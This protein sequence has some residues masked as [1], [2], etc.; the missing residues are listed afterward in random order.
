MKAKKY[1]VILIMLIVLTTSTMSYARDKR[2]KP[3][4]S[5]SNA[6]HVT[7]TKHLDPLKAESGVIVVTV[8]NM[9]DA[10]LYLPKPFTPLYTPQDHLMN[11]IFQVFGEDGKEAKFIGRFIR[12]LQDNPNDYYGRIEPGQAISHEVDLA[13][14]YDLSKG[15]SYQITYQQPFV[16]HIKMDEN[17]QIAGHDEFAPESS[18]DIWV[19]ASLVLKKSAEIVRPLTDGTS[20]VCLQDKQDVI[21][22]AKQNVLPWTK[23]AKEHLNNLYYNE[24]EIDGSGTT[25]YSPKIRQ[26]AA[27]E[28]WFGTPDNNTPGE[29][30]PWNYAEYVD[31]DDFVMFGAV[32]NI[33]SRYGG[34]KYECGCGE[35]Y[36]NTA[37]WAETQK[38]LIHICDKFF[39]LPRE[40]GRGDSQLLT[41]IHELSHFPGSYG[42][43]TV[44]YAYGMESARTLVG[45][46]RH[47]AV[48]NGD[49]LM[50]FIG[51]VNI[52]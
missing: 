52:Q 47:K 41:L 51:T 46:D 44:D 24:P 25:V 16:R 37:A 42:P 30:L 40:Y 14:D 17:G 49:N 3:Y 4:P 1:F 9:T 7:L 33:I 50:Y 11:K 48:R 23:K 19:N 28:E 29:D 21:D 13:T 26:D 10:A 18:L 22:D 36:E 15:G 35:G 31:A 38:N 12:P 32:S 2:D 34:E 27:Y 20:Q 5:T 39:T 45:T 8:R 6:L 43:E